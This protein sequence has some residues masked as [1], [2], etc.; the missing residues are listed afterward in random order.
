MLK[1]WIELG[2]EK[3]YHLHIAMLSAVHFRMRH[4][5]LHR[6][7]AVI[8]NTLLLPSIVE[9]AFLHPSIMTKPLI[10]HS[11]FLKTMTS[12]VCRPRPCS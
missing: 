9:H 2:M 1:L 8:L 10:A 5:T 12:S 3:R 4:G 6:H 7:H 11:S